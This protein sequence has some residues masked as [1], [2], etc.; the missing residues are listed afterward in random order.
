MRGITGAFITLSL[1]L[2]SSQALAHGGHVEEAAGHSHWLGLAAIGAVAI[3]ALLIA[4]SFDKKS[5][6]GK[7]DAASDTIQS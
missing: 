3:L 1:F 2:A 5:D 7:E 6:K 4:K